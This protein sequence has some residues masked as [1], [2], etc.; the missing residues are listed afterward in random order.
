[1]S[2]R[3]ILLYPF[4]AEGHFDM[5]YYINTHLPLVQKHF[6]PHG[7]KSW[8][9]TEFTPETDQSFR[10]QVILSWASA[11][12]ASTA[13]NAPGAKVLKDDIANFSDAEPMAL[14]GSVVKKSSL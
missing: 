12:G 8:E 10:V 14:T 11:E 5:D 7:L 3:T 2:F 13:G 1:M 6:G 9:I 4:K